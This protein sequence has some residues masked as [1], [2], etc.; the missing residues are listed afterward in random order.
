MQYIFCWGFQ[1]NFFPQLQFRLS[2]IFIG[3]FRSKS[4]AKPGH[5]ASPGFPL[6]PTAL[7]QYIFIQRLK[8]GHPVVFALL[9]LEDGLLVNC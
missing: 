3:S 4:G 5:K 7:H 2:R 6:N 8:H 9:W 1:V